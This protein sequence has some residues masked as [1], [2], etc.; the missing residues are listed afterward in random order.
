ME[1]EEILSYFIEFSIL[2]AFFGE[3]KIDCLNK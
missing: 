3:M 2:D 1:G